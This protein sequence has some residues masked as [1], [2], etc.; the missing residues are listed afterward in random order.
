V[1]GITASWLI[2]NSPRFPVLL[3]LDEQDTNKASLDV[4]KADF[5]APLIKAT[6]E[7]YTA[8]SEAF[9]QSNT[10]SDYLKKV[11]ERLREEEDRVERYLNEN[12]RKIVRLALVTVPIY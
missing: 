6:E 2:A 12:T 5:E 3:G 9:L 8:D 10:V 11:E 1:R 7:Y 4:Y